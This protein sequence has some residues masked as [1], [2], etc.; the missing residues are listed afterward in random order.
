MHCKKQRS[1]YIQGLVIKLTKLLQQTVPVICRVIV[2]LMS[3][4][5]LHSLLKYKGDDKE[6]I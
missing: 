1:S 2:L 6:E 4:S 3:E 5:S